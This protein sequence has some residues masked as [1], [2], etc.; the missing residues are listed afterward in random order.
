MSFPWQTGRRGKA[1]PGHRAA[2]EGWVGSLWWSVASASPGTLELRP[3]AAALWRKMNSR[4]TLSDGPLTPYL[5]ESH[6]VPERSV[7][8]GHRTVVS[9]GNVI[10]DPVL[11]P[12]SLGGLLSCVGA[13]L[14]PEI[15]RDS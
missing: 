10:N 1:L 6:G 12:F 9:S 5:Q 14:L 13:L 2:L 15:F 3:F 11:F 4:P 8:S 7:P